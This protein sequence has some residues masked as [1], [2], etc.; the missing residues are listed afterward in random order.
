MIAEFTKSQVKNIFT[1]LL[2]MGG[3]GGSGFFG[4]IASAFGFGGGKA[5]GGGVSAGKSYM[6]GERGPEMFSPRGAGVIT[7]NSA[8][9]GVSNTT[10]T[11][12]IQAVDASSFKSLVAQ[13]PEF[14]YGVSERGRKNL[15]LRSRL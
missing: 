14:I 9:G 11:Y 3:S 6:V 8:F 1:N 2:G 7:P 15:P 12:N 4:A 5:T 13:D 10:V